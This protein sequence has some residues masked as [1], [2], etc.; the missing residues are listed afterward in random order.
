V[1]AYNEVLGASSPSADV[2]LEAEFS[3][4]G[5]SPNIRLTTPVSAGQRIT[6]IKRVGKTWYNRGVNTATT[7]N[8]F[9]GN[10]TPMIKFIKEKSTELPE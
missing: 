3:V 8:T 4:D 1:S 2:I 5:T 10:D 6:V 9:L 7:G